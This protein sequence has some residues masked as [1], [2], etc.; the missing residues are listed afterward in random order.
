MFASWGLLA[1]GADASPGMLRLA[2]AHARERG[3]RARFVRAAY[4]E[5]GKAIPRR[6]DAVIT[7]G[8]SL[9][10]VRGQAELAA[11]LN[12]VRVLLKP[13]GLFLSQTRNY[14]G[15]REEEIEALPVTSKPEQGREALFL[16]L[17]QRQGNRI[18]F[19]L[20]KLAREGRAWQASTRMTWFYRVTRRRLAQAAEQAGFVRAHWFGGYDL[21]RFAPRKSPDLVLLA[22]APGGG[23][24]RPGQRCYPE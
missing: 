23:K 24:P 1:W 22:R 2:R 15:Y 4:G 7:I 10:Q 16:R 17:H 20:V 21:S 12:E 8:N 9:V 11:L 13:G 19:Y 5:L 14:D 18:R 6:F 3:V